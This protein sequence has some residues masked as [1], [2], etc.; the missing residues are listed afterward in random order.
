MH[1]AL[2]AVVCAVL[3]ATASAMSL[4][5][6]ALAGDGSYYLVRILGSESI[7]GPDTRV[8]GNALRQVPVLL[9][10]RSGVTDTFVHSVLL[11]VGQL[12]LPAAIW[13]L[14]V[15]LSRRNE[16]AFTATAMTAGL[17]AGTT[18]FFSTG[19]SAIAIPLT[20]LVGALLWQP[21]AWTKAQACLALVASLLLVATYGSAVVTGT[22][23]GAWAAW[24]AAAARSRVD[25]LGGAAVAVLAALSALVAAAG[26]IYGRESSTWARSSLYFVASGE[27]WQFYVAL[28]AVAA[29]VAALIVH[30]N[31]RLGLIL[32]GVAGACAA[33]AISTLP[34]TP[35]ASFQARGGATAAGL[36]LVFFMWALWIHDERVA[37][38]RSS[39]AATGTRW[40][41]LAPVV[42]VCAMGVASVHGL[43]AWSRSLEA[44]RDEVDMAR[45]TVSVDDVLPE[46]RRLVVWGWT[47]SSL[48]LIVR[49]DATSGVLVDRDPSYVPFPP[50]TAREQLSDDY[51]WR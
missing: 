35:V 51:R 49:R 13:S 7:F 23:L 32:L 40:L 36:L 15:V 6:L 41:R 26:L 5:S 46:E 47:S 12:V 9:A 27:P 38:R 2:V 31:R 50:S 22:V 17:C 20:V 14:A 34:A 29:A 8:L 24:R 10:A 44:F 21:A 4:R 39:S 33:L 16:V 18:W 19:E 43:G 11:G 48:S 30:G 42:F 1:P 28:V 3:V 25:R 37:P 45:S